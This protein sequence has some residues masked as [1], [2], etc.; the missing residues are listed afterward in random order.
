MGSQRISAMV[1][2][3]VKLM[4]DEIAGLWNVI[5]EDGNT[6][7]ARHVINGSGGLHVPSI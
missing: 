1:K 5:F 4:F 7:K 3:I 6:V 2:K